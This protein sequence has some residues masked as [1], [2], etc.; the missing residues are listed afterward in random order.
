MISDKLLLDPSVYYQWFVTE[1]YTRASNGKSGDTLC[2]KLQCVTENVKTVIC[3]H[4]ND[5]STCE[6]Y[7]QIL[8]QL[9]ITDPSVTVPSVFIRGYHLYAKVSPVTEGNG[10]VK[11]LIQAHTVTDHLSEKSVNGSLSEKTVTDHLSEKTVNRSRVTKTVT[12][13]LS[14]KTPYA[15]AIQQLEQMGPEYVKEYRVQRKL[16][17]VV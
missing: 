3:Y 12:D 13:L 1:T 16:G 17:G 7:K 6:A 4:S 9:G 14:E 15:V 11:H 10:K 5:H 8:N 2:I